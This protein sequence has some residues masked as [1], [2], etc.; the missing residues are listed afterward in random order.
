MRPGLAGCGAEGHDL[1]V[2]RERDPASART[3]VG[4]E[5][6]GAGRRVDRLAVDLEADATCEH[7][8]ELLV[9][10]QRL[11]VL[12]HEQ[13]AGVSV[14]RIDPERLD[15]EL[16]P[17]R[18][19]VRPVLRNV[20]DARDGPGHPRIASTSALI[21]SRSLSFAAHVRTSSG[22]RSNAWR[23]SATAPS[24]SPAS[25]RKRARL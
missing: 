22:E 2:V 23:K 3:G 11:V 14:R 8:I 13:V 20:G 16:Q 5:D 1:R 17:H 21:E 15:P 4:D 18:P 24:R 6:E 9:P 12:E 25:A 7:E 10:A 19:P